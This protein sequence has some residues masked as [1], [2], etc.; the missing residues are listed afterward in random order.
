[1]TGEFAVAAKK[2]LW[3]FSKFKIKPL[4]PTYPPITIRTR[5]KI[6][7][8][9]KTFHIYIA[10]NVLLP[11]IKL[12]TIFS[13]F[14]RIKIALT[15]CIERLVDRHNAPLRK[16]LYGWNGRKTERLWS[17]QTTHKAICERIPTTNM[18]HYCL[19][20]FRPREESF[21]QVLCLFTH[22]IPISCH[23]IHSAYIQYISTSI[24]ICAGWSCFDVSHASQNHIYIHICGYVVVAYVWI[25]IRVVS[26][27]GI[28]QSEA[29]CRPVPP[30]SFVCV[31]PICRRRLRKRAKTRHFRRL[32]CA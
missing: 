11:T 16:G 28:W 9:C 4:K 26:A 10:E 14:E 27:L 22:R 23:V 31:S 1:M 32:F 13:M 20:H 15:E 3:S 5:N 29:R 21:A 6:Y 30:S 19:L 17:W 24:Y 2:F 18:R 25:D 12:A 8:N 7:D